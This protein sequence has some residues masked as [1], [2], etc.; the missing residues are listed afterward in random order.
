MAGNSPDKDQRTVEEIMNEADPTHA[1]TSSLF[2]YLGTLITLA[3]IA[4]IMWF[5]L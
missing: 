1:S 4:V 3:I 5:L 2:N